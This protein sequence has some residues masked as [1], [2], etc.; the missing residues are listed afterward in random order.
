VS[1]VGEALIQ[2]AGNGQRPRSCRVKDKNCWGPSGR[3]LKITHKVRKAFT[4]QS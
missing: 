2:G 4:L 1:E 3:N